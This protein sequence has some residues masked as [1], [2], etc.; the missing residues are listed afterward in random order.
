MI[1]NINP[2]TNPVTTFLGVFLMVIS[3]GMLIVPMF[4]EVKETLDWW[5]PATIG[6]VGLS[7]LLIPDD[8]KGGLKKLI[9]RKSDSI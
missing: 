7:L 5:L 2:K 4:Y 8:L 3:I 6:V 9:N 1:N